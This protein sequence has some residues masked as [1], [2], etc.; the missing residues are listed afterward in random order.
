LKNFPIFAAALTRHETQCPFLLVSILK[1]RWQFSDVFREWQRA[2]FVFLG[3]GG[4]IGVDT[5]IICA[6]SGGSAHDSGN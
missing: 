5:E 3:E 6:K 1:A 4:A 2:F